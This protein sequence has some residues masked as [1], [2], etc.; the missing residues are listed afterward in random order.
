MV[1][2]KS[3]VQFVP[4]HSVLGFTI[5]PILTCS[6]AAHV[7]YPRPEDLME[8]DDVITTEPK[9]DYQSVGTTP[10]TDKDK[11]ED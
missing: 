3:T 9:A 10:S 8:E 1:S 6:N 5:H 4:F 11:I 2:A 7:G